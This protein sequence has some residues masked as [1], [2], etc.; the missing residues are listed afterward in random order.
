[1]NRKFEQPKQQQTGF[2]YHPAVARTIPTATLED[3]VANNNACYMA[4]TPKERRV[5]IARDALQQLR[6]SKV[7]AQPGVYLDTR[8]VR[9][10]TAMISKKVSML[11][12]LRAIFVKKKETEDSDKN[13]ELEPQMCF[14]CAKGALM[15]SAMRFIPESQFRESLKSNE[16][17]EPVADSYYKGINWPIDNWNLIEVAFELIRTHGTRHGDSN[18]TPNQLDRAVEFGEQYGDSDSRLQAILENI[19]ANNGTFIP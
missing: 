9:H 10:L 6:L 18:L 3:I 14:A 17:Q 7:I 16:S 2:E 1:M 12:A 19:I 15:L 5:M 11:G 13:S 4:A 8:I